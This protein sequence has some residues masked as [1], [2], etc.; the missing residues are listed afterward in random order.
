MRACV[1]AAAVGSVEQAYAA[2]DFFSLAC[3]DHFFLWLAGVV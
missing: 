3:L 2:K 1:C